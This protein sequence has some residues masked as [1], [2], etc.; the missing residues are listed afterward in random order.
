M[1]KK[2]I[3]FLLIS[4][5]F[6]S[7]IFAND[8]VKKETKKKKE[9]SFVVVP[10]PSYNPQTKF[11]ITV[12][13][14]KLFKTNKKD[15]VSPPS[16]VVGFANGTTNKS[17]ILG[18]GTRL[19]F[20]EDTWRVKAGVFRGNFEG[21][22]LVFDTE[23]FVG[24][25]S[26][27]FVYTANLQRKIFENMYIGGGFVTTDI[28]FKSQAGFQNRTKN[29]GVIG[30]ANYDSK[31]NQFSPTK[32]MLASAKIT[33]YREDLGNDYNFEVLGLSYRKYHSFNKNENRVFAG[34]FESS[35]GFGP[36][37]S[38]YNYNYGRGGSQRGYTGTVFEGKNM[39]RFEGEYRHYFEKILK[40]RFG[41]SLFAGL[42]K[43]Y[44]GT[45]KVGN[46]LPQSISDAPILPHIGTGVRYK[47]VPEKNIISRLDFAY[48]KEKEF[49]M[50]FAIS[51]AI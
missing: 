29:T 45:S 28:D 51:E 33:V 13:A 7:A 42:G 50:Y 17:W 37:N 8:E 46:N 49:T 25:T 40:A 43:V 27:V 15:E 41:T 26:S 21:E 1:F 39:L 4:I 12:I 24:N 32:G 3:K 20:K 31:N 5:L 6:S 48:G 9:K 34:I 36:D 19:Y 47:L 23:R 11:G 30:E 14:M 18:L 38:N 35:F 10:G 16:S 2:I 22:M 44:G